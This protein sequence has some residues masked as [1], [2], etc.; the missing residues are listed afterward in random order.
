M[1]RKP[2]FWIALTAL[3]AGAIYFAA[4]F[5]SRAFPIVALDL[6]MDRETALGKAKQLEARFH[7]GPD[8]FRQAASFAG[9]QSVQN[10]VELEAGGTEPFKKM[11]ADGLYHAYKWTVRHFKPG[12]T[13]ETRIRFTPRG[14]PY[15]FVVKLPEN[16]PGA[17]LEADSARTIADQSASNEWGIDLGKYQLE[18]KSQ[19]VRPGGR[20]DHTFVYE[21]TDARIGEGRYRLRLVV[22]GDKLTELTH[23]VKVPEAF[24]RRLRRD[25][26]GEQLDQRHWNYSPRYPLPDRR[27]WFW[28]VLPAPAPVDRLAHASVLG[29]VDRCASVARWFQRVAACLDEL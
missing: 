20:V 15:G 10:F 9:D 16:E 25:A 27:V 4:R 26:L 19:E 22:G 12:E 14:D 17:T 11:T 23:F 13:R 5:F 29:L 3:S 8:G 6:Q 24:S 2:L 28:I 1:F 18:E 21:R 7:F